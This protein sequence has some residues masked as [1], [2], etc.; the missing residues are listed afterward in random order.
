[1]KVKATK[2]DVDLGENTRAIIRLGGYVWVEYKNK[3]WLAQKLLP[4]FVN[5]F[6][7]RAHH[8]PNEIMYMIDNSIYKLSI[9]DSIKNKMV[10]EY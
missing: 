6:K 4:M 8:E 10:K 1:M 5:Y 7:P 2:I 9:P 3:S